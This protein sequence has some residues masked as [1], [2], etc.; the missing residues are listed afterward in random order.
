MAK[1]QTKNSVLGLVIL[2]ICK[3]VKS[4][5]SVISKIRCKA[6]CKYLLQFD[7]LVLKQG[8]LHQI[9]ITNDIES[10]QL[11]LPLKYDEAVLHMLHDDYGHHGLDWKLA[12]VRGRFYWSTM[13]QDVTSYVTNCHWCH[14]AK[15]YYTGPH[16]QQWS[17][18]A[19]NPLDL[20]CIDFLKVDPSKDGKENILVLT[21]AFTKFSQAFITNTQKALAITKI[22][23][24][25]W[26]YIYGILAQHSQ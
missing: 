20:L 8:V 7:Q 4:K 23:V 19:N 1:A 2:F 15:G 11:V 10:H 22:L 24:D 17:I 14:V 13:N 12:L 16:T 9:Y 5:G 26:Y 25:K 21:D 18:V 6:V 3:G